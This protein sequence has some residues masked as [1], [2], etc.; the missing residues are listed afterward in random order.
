M[1]RNYKIRWHP[2]NKAWTSACGEL[3]KDGKSRKPVYFREIPYGPEGSVNHRKAK[4]AL[5]EHLRLRDAKVEMAGELSIGSLAKLYLTWLKRRIEAGKAKP[6]TM[7]GHRAALKKFCA[8]SPKGGIR[9]ADRPAVQLTATGVASIVEDWVAEGYAPNYVGRIVASL[10]AVLNWA[11]DPL[12]GRDPERLI[13]S[14]PLK[15]FSHEATKA[16]HPP[17]RYAEGE[18]VRSFLAWGYAR[19]ERI[20]GLAG[21]F[22]RLTMDLIRVAYLAGTRPGELRVAE[23]GDFEARAARVEQLGEWWGRITLDPSRWKSGGK[24]GK[25]REVFLPPEAVAAIEEILQLPDHHPRFIWTHRRGTRSAD[26]GAT[27][28]PH[29]EPWSE[30]SLPTKICTLRRLA[31]KEGIT[32]RDE[33]PD[34]FVMYRLRHSRAAELLMA[35]VDVATVAKLLGTS[36]Q[37]IETVYGSFKSEHLA[38][39]ASRAIAKVALPATKADQGPP[40][41]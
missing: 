41:A 21:R 28:R 14:N 25:A 39:A 4:A 29:G 38:E 9:M 34:R 36:V 37:M 2:G 31:I 24:T 19:A 12:A 20:G 8:V 22:E 3:G 11:A 1:P 6:N 5:E 32:V 35:G 26:R 40:P 23:R 18:E 17:D 33:G 27:S 30:S 16:P 7:K 13:A 10:Q 15:G